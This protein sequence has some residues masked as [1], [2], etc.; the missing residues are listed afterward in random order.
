MMTPNEKFYRKWA[1]NI[2]LRAIDDETIIFR[3]EEELKEYIKEQAD[4]LII[5]PDKLWEWTI[6]V[7]KDL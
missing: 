4:L 1:E 5:D 6:R 3:S 7:Y 2:L